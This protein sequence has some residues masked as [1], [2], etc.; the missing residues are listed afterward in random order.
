MRK[1]YGNRISD[2]FL[3]NIEDRKI[4]FMEDG[5]DLRN[6][7]IGISEGEEIFNNFV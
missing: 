4:V 5:S 1:T 2:K 3:E 7:K 6:M